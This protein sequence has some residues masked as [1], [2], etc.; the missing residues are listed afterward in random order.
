[1]V[2]YAV[3]FSLLAGLL[4]T[5]LANKRRGKILSAEDYVKELEELEKVD[6]KRGEDVVGTAGS[7]VRTNIQTI[8]DSFNVQENWERYSSVTMICTVADLSVSFRS[9]RGK[10]I[11][12]LRF[13]LDGSFLDDIQ[14]TEVEK[15][16]L[17]DAIN[18]WEDRE[19]AVHR[20]Q[21]EL[22][23]EKA[24]AKILQGAKK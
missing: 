11:V 10:L 19:N 23:L 3:A 24:V 6:N 9:S 18:A 12:R 13:T 16:K 1:M 8:I 21:V 2:C 22:S 4:V 14:L 20:K 15:D 17:I 5:F 7:S